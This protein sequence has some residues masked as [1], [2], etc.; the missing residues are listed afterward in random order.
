MLVKAE[1]ITFFLV[2]D[3]LSKRPPGEYYLEV[4]CGSCYCFVSLVG[5]VIP[6]ALDLGCV[7]G[8]DSSVLL[9]QDGN[10]DATVASSFPNSKRSTSNTEG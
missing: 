9:R 8:W 2:E 5:E 10:A 6:P 7:M 1:R 3:N 4:S